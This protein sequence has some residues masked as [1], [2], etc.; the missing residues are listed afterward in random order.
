MVFPVSLV[1][2]KGPVPVPTGLTVPSVAYAFSERMPR[3]GLARRSGR[4][5]SAVLVLM[6]TVSA[7]SASAVSV[8]SLS[9]RG[10]VSAAF[11][12]SS[13]LTTDAAV[14][15]VPSWKVALRSS[16]VQVVAFFRVQDLASAG[17]AAPSSSRAVSP[18][19]TESLLSTVASLLYGDR[20]CTGGTARAIRRR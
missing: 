11:A 10:L 1:I 17:A 13:A 18:S 9:T 7:S 14:T 20:A 5:G 15:S 8:T 2:A 19:A 6:V 4:T 16:K 3:A 12:W